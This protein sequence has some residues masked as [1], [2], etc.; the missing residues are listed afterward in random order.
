LPLRPCTTRDP[1]LWSQTSTSAARTRGS[2]DRGSAGRFRACRRTARSA[3][4][5]LGKGEATVRGHALAEPEPRELPRPVTRSTATATPRR[6]HLRRRE[7][8]RNRRRCGSRR[9]I[10]RARA[11]KNSS[12]PPPVTS[13]SRHGDGRA[14]AA[15]GGPSPAREEEGWREEDGGQI[16]HRRHGAPLRGRGRRWRRR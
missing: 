10:Q 6:R 8:E 3:A 1:S 4:P 11:V 14:S 15:A 9:Q 12:S 5:G 2:G 13:L 16:Q 7:E